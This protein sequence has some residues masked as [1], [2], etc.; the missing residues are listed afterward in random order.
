MKSKDFQKLVLSKYETGD[1]PAKIFRDLNGAI[2]L[3]TIERWCKSIRA[4]GC[5]NLSRSPG[6]PR[7]IRTKTSVRKIKHQ[8][9]R[10]K[11]VSSRRLARELGISRTSVR[12]VLKDDL[13]LQAYKIQNKPLLTDEH[14][15]KRIKFANWI[16]TNF[17]KEDTM[18]ILFFDE[19]MFDIDGVYNSQNDRI[20]AV[21]RSEADTKDGIQQKVMVWLGVFSKGVSPLVIFENGTVDHDR[22]IKEVLPV[23]LKY[24]NA[25]FGNDWTFQQDGVKPH[26]HAKTQ[27]WCG[28]KFPSFIDKD[29]WPPNSPD[30]N[31]LDYCIWDQ[32]AQTIKWNT[33]TSKKTLIVAL[34]RA[35]REISKDAV[36]ESCSS[37]TN[38]LYRLSQNKGNYLR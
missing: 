33:V 28:N 13:G 22:Y 26:I 31:P 18:K 15:E 32:L 8:M 30:S 34:K 20:W 6:R 5:I 7:T 1:G 16:R 4:T 17:R 9:E 38:R 23:A 14:K 3:R 36:F 37:W 2:S 35:V 21:N 19:K 27:E 29:H 25:M 12:R 11:S 10:R 24:G